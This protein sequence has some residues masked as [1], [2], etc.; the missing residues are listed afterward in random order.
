MISLSVAYG[1]RVGS[2]VLVDHAADQVPALHGCAGL[3]DDRVS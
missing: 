2:P 3:G 1:V